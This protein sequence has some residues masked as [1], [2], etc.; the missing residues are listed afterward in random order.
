MI[1]GDSDG[2]KEVEKVTSKALIAEEIIRPVNAKETSSNLVELLNQTRLIAK[3]R[4]ILVVD[5]SPIFLRT[6]MGWLDPHYNVSICPSA[7]TALQK[8]DA[9]APDLILLDYEMPACSGDKFLEMLRSDDDTKD[10]PVIFLTSKND[11]GT[12]SKVLSMKPQGYI[13]KTQTK[14]NILK[15]IS[16]FFKSVT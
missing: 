6:A 14:D 9:F 3:R 13:L 4:K 16:D 1:I 2:L 5:D 12:V 8:I 11:Q 7:A 15:N 10:I